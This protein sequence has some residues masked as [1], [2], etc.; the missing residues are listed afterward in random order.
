MLIRTTDSLSNRTFEIVKWS[1]T[2]FSGLL[3]TGLIILLES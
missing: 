3:T 2:A 1:L